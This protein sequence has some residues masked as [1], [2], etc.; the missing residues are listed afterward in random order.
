VHDLVDK[1]GLLY[2]ERPKNYVTDI[3]THA[4]SMVFTGHTDT[5]KAKRKMATHH[6]SVGHTSLHGRFKASLT[7]V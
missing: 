1:K 6:F 4:D 5:Q 2:A 7:G 3:V